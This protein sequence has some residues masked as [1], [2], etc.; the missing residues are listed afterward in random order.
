MGSVKETISL[1]EPTKTKSGK[2]SFKFSDRFS[3]LDWG[4]MP[5][6]IPGKGAALCTMAASN[7]EMLESE[8][9][10]THYK[11][12]I[13]SSG[14]IVQTSDLTEPSNEMVIKL[15]RVI[16]PIFSEGEFDYKFFIE[17]KGELNNFV[18]PLEVIY[19]KGAPLGSS[20]FKKIK[21]LEGKD[22]ELKK[23]LSQYGLTEP[24]KPGDFFPE[25]CY[26]FTTK[27]EPQDRR[28]TNDEA[29]RIS[30]LSKEQFEELENLRNKVVKLISGR[31]DEV[32]FKDYDGKQ[33]YIFS[34]KVMLADVAGT[35]DEDRFMLNGEQISK[36]FLRQYYKKYQSEWY[37]ACE[38]TKKKAKENG[39]KDWRTLVGIQPEPLPPELVSLVGE[40]YMAGS[41]RY[42]G[43]N[44]F[45]IRSLE[46]VMDDLRFYRD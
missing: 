1:I 19:R 10:P 21:E 45:N 32:G 4:A 2:G 13:N 17:N 46:T 25:T 38:I 44:L 42:T 11:G 18:I 8:G 37:N 23:F 7:F 28:I 29:Y 16:E 12:I 41:D 27:F 40:M 30:G 39:I 22:E 3:I 31:A 24:P 43:L 36:E 26:D 14:E 34:N 33:E 9:I 35:F 15:A 5:D 6:E 20:L